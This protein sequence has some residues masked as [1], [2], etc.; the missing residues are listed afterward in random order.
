MF[1]NDMMKT[2]VTQQPGGTVIYGY[3]KD[4]FNLG[5]GSLFVQTEIGRKSYFS[6]GHER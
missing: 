6:F 1:T 5:G 2:R 3:A 4:I